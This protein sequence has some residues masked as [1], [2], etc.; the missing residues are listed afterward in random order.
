MQ[1]RWKRIP[2]KLMVVVLAGLLQPA[3]RDFA[4]DRDFNRLVREV[5]SRFHAKRMHVPLFG[6]AK[7]VIKVMRRGSK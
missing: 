4:E 1:N 5:E 7:P 2:V 3:R 6:V